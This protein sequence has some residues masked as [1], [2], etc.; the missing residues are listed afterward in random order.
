DIFAFLIL[1]GSVI[2]QTNAIP[3]TFPGGN[4]QQTL[5][6]TVP[7]NSAVVNRSVPVVVSGTSTGLNSGTVIQVQ[8]YVSNGPTLVAQGTGQ[9][10]NAGNWSATL[11]FNL[12]VNPGAGGYI[13]AS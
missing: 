2:A 1:N 7:A 13:T 6:I 3:L 5:T 4:P 9:T 8:G 10:N 11:N 12:A